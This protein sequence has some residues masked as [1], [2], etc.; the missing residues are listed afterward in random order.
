MDGIAAQGNYPYRTHQSEK[1]NRHA[2][3]KVEEVY[4]L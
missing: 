2:E 4:S 3:C 1:V